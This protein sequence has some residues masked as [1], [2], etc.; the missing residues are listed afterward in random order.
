MAD[1]VAPMRPAKFIDW[2]RHLGLEL[3]PELCQY[4]ADSKKVAEAQMA[5]NEAETEMHNTGRNRPDAIVSEPN[6]RRQKTWQRIALGLAVSDYGYNPNLP[7]SSAP[8]QISEHLK[9]VAL[10]VSDDTIRDCLREAVEDLGYD[11]SERASAE[12]EIHSS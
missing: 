2:A 1:L 4:A 11:S 9:R 3:P 5:R 7:R 8:R 10:F 6:T 12:D